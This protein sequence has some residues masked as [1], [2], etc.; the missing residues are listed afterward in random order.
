MSMILIYVLFH[1]NQVSLKRKLKKKYVSIYYLSI[2]IDNKEKN[3][4]LDE[5][6]KQAFFMLVERENGNLRQ[7]ALKRGVEYATINKLKNGKSSFAKMSIQTLEKLFPFLRVSFFGEDAH[8]V[9]VHGTNN[10]A[11]AAGAGAKATVNG[12][13]PIPDPISVTPS[14][15]LDAISRVSLE[16]Q[17]LHAQDFSND[18]RI[19]FL[20]FLRDK[21]R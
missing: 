13:K 20:L 19:K 4:A 6:V 16:N 8:A 10:G 18:E 12:L 9:M 5:Q 15:P 1:K 7:L 2:L 11:I 14:V 21:V 17:I 3:M